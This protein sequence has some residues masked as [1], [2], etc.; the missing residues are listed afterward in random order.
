MEFS[1]SFEGVRGVWLTFLILRNS[2]FTA[3]SLSGITCAS[4]FV[5]IAG[6]EDISAK[7]Q[8]RLISLSLTDNRGFEADRLD[9]ELDDSDGALM[10]PK[11]GEI[12][13]LHLG[14]QGENLIHKGSFTVDEIEHSGV[15]N[16]MTLRA[17]SADFRATLNVR[18]EMSY[19]QKTLGDIV[20]TIAGRNNVTAVVDPGLDTVK[21]EHI[22]QTNE[23]DGS[24]LTRLGQLNGA[25]ACVKNGSLLFMVQESNTT[26]S[27]QALSLVWITR[28]VGD[29]HRFSLVDRGAYTGV[30]A[31]YL[32]TRKPQEKTQSQI[33]RR[34]PTTDK[35]K[36][37]EEKQGEYLVGEEGN[38]MV[39]FHT[40]ASKTNAERAAK[41]AWEKIQ[42]GVASFSITLAKGRADLFPELPVQV[43]GFK[44][45]IDNAYWTLVTVSHSL[46][47]SGFTTSLELEVKSSDIDMD[48]E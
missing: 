30:T 16:K 46:N 41:A 34:K 15:P 28:S 23:S 14:W 5:L 47:N 11:R 12:L 4:A 13:T 9:I 3:I 33:R 38:V 35:P 1:P 36:K 29:G 6:D 25:T 40:Y 42:R 19:H 18:R 2:S 22:D 7:I 8:G 45:E 32:N 21:I 10:M 37:E 26:A 39:L 43:S 20:R 17:R 31:N 44:P 48:K 27:G 24:F